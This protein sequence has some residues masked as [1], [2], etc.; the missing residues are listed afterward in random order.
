MQ[1]TTST[2][3][4]T[5]P[6]VEVLPALERALQQFSRIVLEAPPGA[7]KSTYLPLWLLQRDASPSQR[8]V[9]IQPRRIAASNVARYLARQC[10]TELGGRVG[11]R[12]RYDHKVSA[13]TAIEVI[14]EGIFLRQIQRDP[15]LQGVRYVLFDEYHERSWQA[16]VSLAFALEAQAQWREATQP[17]CILVMSATLPAAAVANWLDAPV[18]RAAGRSFPV[19]V[20]YCPPTSQE[21]G[22]P[23]EHLTRQVIAALN[24]GSR[25]I[26][27]FLSGWQAIQRVRERL[28]GRCTASIQVLH[29]SLPPEQQQQAL[30][31][32][33]PGTQSV[34][35]ATNIAE[36]SLTIEGVDT[37][38]DSGQERRPRF[39]PSRGMDRLETGWISRASAEQR[40]G[41]AGRL[42]PGR[43]I[44]LWSQEQQGR[45]V[46]HDTAE[47]HR[48]DLAPLALELALWGSP[49]AIDELLPEAPQP[50]RLGEA[51][52]LLGELG[53]LD[54][55]QRLTGIGRKMAELGLH[56]R[57]GRLVLYGREHDLLRPACRLAALLSEGDF[58][59]RDG[60]VLS[61]DIEL[62]LQRL[63]GNVAP[64][65]RGT[66]ERIRQ[67]SRQLLERSGGGKTAG[68]EPAP[69]AGGQ[70]LLSAFPDRVA[71]RRP[72]GNGR[73]L[74]MDG[75][76]LLLDSRD[77]LARESWLVVAE[78]NGARQGARITL[79]AGVTD[80][81]VLAAWADR[82]EERELLE[83]DEAAQRLMAKKLRRLGALVLGEQSLAI[84]DERANA[85]W[86]RELRARGCVWLN[87]S[88]PVRQW[89]ERVRWAARAARDW[90][91][92]SEAGLLAALEDWLLPYLQG[93]RRLEQLRA[94]DFGALLR[95]RLDYARQQEL[96]RLAPERLQLPSGAAHVIEYRIGEPPRL[97]AR[98]TEFYG[99]DRHP[100]VAGE[101]L[102]LELLS[103][104][105]R[106]VQLTQDIVGFWRGSYPDV[107]KEMK[108][109]YPKHFWPE[110]P[111]AAPAT[112]VT[113]KRMRP[114]GD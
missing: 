95:A 84:D 111:W 11:L 14:T 20:D 92:F 93:V 106:P 56:P 75:F 3:P 48:I 2:S 110:E 10:N 86:L 83:W 13:E 38:I 57:L 74:G 112:T 36:T 71:L 104:A 41:R 46:A 1:N 65:Q 24:E 79:A 73:Y 59:P 27:V 78:H 108:G 54:E 64:A 21:R 98:L 100:I 97:A 32:P 82:I 50:Q 9:L 7:G 68:G 60:D 107:R 5:L 34:V 109:R 25:R 30:A 94:L 22:D 66:V 35:L 51:R 19:Q 96:A 26:L 80:G 91:D 55:R 85:I 70:L 58:L 44:R 12:T 101:P 113:K 40:A 17:L 89:L 90:P 37:V 15:E 52:E 42:G 18:V 72:G 45:L 8:I 6:I 88:E 53:A 76:E 62:R 87:W 33:P 61:A 49:S 69:E 114:L 99:L 29:S 47:I 31:A 81:Q 103:P 4:K 102:L 67:L 28:G 63:D 43:C 39:D 23:A 16:D 77:P 105:H